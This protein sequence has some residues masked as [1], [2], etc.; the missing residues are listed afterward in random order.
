MTPLMTDLDQFF[1]PNGRVRLHVT[2][3][4]QADAETV[5]LLHGGPG[6]PDPMSE[7]AFELN[8]QYRVVTFEQ[9]GTGLSTNPE[10]DYSMAAYI[11]DV[12][13]IAKHFAI[14]T[15]HLFGHSWGG[16]YAQIYA[17]ERPECIKS[18][19]LCSP[20][21]GTNTL[22]QQTEK[23]VMQFNK[24]AAGFWNWMGMGWNSLLG[25]LG[26][27]RAYRKIFFQVLTNYHQNF[28]DVHVNRMQLEAVH[29]KPINK[30]RAAI[31]AYKS[32]SIVQDPPFPIL[33]AYGANDIYGESKQEVQ[34]RYPTSTLV[35]INGAGHIPWLHNPMAFGQVL[36]RFYGRAK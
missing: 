13:A 29:A 26:S 12:D 8:K 6:V 23:E 20:S 7:V 34:K 1:I 27:D 14:S 16:L 11:S 32:L 24:R 31:I 10:E 4:P 21:S 22:W 5:I 15:F 9:R 3:Y 30:S 18:L 25:L 19:F 33:I 2:V 36:E 17:E 35:E 28:P